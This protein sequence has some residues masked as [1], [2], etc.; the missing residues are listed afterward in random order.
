[1]N[2]HNTFIHV[3]LATPIIILGDMNTDPQSDVYNQFIDFHNGLKSAYSLY[4]AEGEPEHTTAKVSL[5][6]K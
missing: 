6:L 2:F 1:M 3:L 5:G 4:R